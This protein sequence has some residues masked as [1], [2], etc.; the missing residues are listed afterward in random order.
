MDSVY[1]TND[2]ESFAG[3]GLDK[4]TANESIFL[5]EIGSLELFCRQE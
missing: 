5:G 3:L 2:V 4:F 1:P